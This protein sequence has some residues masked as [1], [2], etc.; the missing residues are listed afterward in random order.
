M[1]ASKT[2]GKY[3]SEWYHVH[4]S[5]VLRNPLFPAEVFFN[6]K[7][8]PSTDTAHSMIEL[9]NQLREFYLH[10]IAQE[11]LYIGSPDLYEQLLLW[12][13]NKIEKKDKKEKIEL[14][15]VKYMVRMC[16]RC[17]PYGLFAS[18]T[19]GKI[20][21]CTKIHLQE[22][23]LLQRFGRL[24]MDYVCEL[25]SFLLKQKEI[26]AQLLFY[27][28]TSLYSHGTQ[29]RYIEHRFQKETGRSYHVVQIDQSAYLEKILEAARNGCIQKKLVTIIT[30]DEILFEEANE[31]ITE[32]IEAQ[33]LVSELEPN[34]TGEE[35]F[36][37]LLRKLK[38]LA[39]T[40]EIV[41][42][43]E[44]VTKEFEQLSS[45]SV[46]FKNKVYTN[47]VQHLQQLEVPV[48]LKTLIQVDSFRPASSCMLNKKVADEI[49]NGIGLLQVLTTDNSINDQF[50]DFKNAFVQR[51]ES[52]WIPLVAV[53]D[54]ESG[55]GY[56]KFAT[57]GMEES[58]LIDKLPIGD[59]KALPQNQNVSDTE[60]F[61]WQL[62][63]EAISQNKTE[64]FI[65]DKVIELFSKKEFLPAGLPDSMYMMVR[66]NARS[67]LDIDQGNYTITLQPPAGP[68]GGTL[69]GRFC[70]LN[71]EIKNFTIKILQDEEA[72]KPD[73]VFAEIVHLPESRIGNVL[74][75]P[76][77]RSYEI[78]YL[79][80][81]TL[82]SEFQIP[83]T[84]LL[85]GIE[86][87]KIMIR[88]KRLNKI[89]IPTNDYCT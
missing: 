40:E 68:S 51:Y 70:N 42:Q 30:N 72:H 73:C 5:F 59:A 2:Y 21:D 17:T 7:T 13:E 6:W 47:I 53:L 52:Q 75:R 83:V 55:I 27:P 11:A 49:L 25:L 79:C 65:D 45:V 60:I 8:E 85:V 66:I 38:T 61:K 39:H 23:N 14:S 28:N 67:S 34:I 15:L 37:V 19:V 22:K 50:A 29:W 62:Y 58:P 10:P 57:I 20:S 32:L 71:E 81:T 63:H 56:G 1:N 80:G 76:Q 41:V 31:F 18:C 74:M 84:D 24:D 89:V 78:P 82:N 64:V 35:Y 88:S 3:F 36:S 9:R 12:L 48:H 54:T 4:D 87:N 46:E 69:L 16:T 86:E 44:N 43:L 33:I 77:L 26:A